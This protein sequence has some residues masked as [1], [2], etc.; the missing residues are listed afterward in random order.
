[1]A[2]TQL[3]QSG[4]APSISVAALVHG[5]GK[6]IAHMDAGNITQPLYLLCK[7]VVRGP[8]V[9]L[10]RICHHREGGACVHIHYICNAIYL[11]RLR[12][13][14]TLVQKSAQ[15][16]QQIAPIGRYHRVFVVADRCGGG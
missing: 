14:V 13:A 8:L 3:A 1:M 2:D 10:A 11:Y 4:R 12:L 16:P 15:S 5:N 6:V 9:H 7:R